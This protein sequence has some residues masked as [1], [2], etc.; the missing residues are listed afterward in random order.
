MSRRGTAEEKTAKSDPIY[1]NRLVNMLVNRILKHGK[2]SLAYQIIYRAVKKIQQKTERN[3]LSVLRQAIRGV[4][5]DIAIKTKRVGGS[6]NQVPIEIGSTQGKALAIR[7]LLEASQKRPGR[8]TASKL[9]S[10]LVDAAKGSGD[11]IRKKEDTYRRAE[12][13]R[14]FAHFR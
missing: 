7:W 4:S 9:S 2:K 3:P 14:A 11:A 6:T 13:N 8:N 12:A 5:P 1:R 10:E